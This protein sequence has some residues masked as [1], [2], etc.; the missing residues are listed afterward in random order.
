MMGLGASE[1]FLAG[2]VLKLVNHVIE[3]IKELP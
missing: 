1:Q 3:D 2:K